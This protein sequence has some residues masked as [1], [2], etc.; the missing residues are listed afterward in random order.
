MCAQ[1]KRL[2]EQEGVLDWEKKSDSER[3]EWVVK[4]HRTRIDAAVKS[5]RTR[6]HSI[7]EMGW[8]TLAVV[9][10]KIM[11]LKPNTFPHHDTH[12]CSRRQRIE[13]ALLTSQWDKSPKFG[14]KSPK[15]RKDDH[16]A[17]TGG[18]GTKYQNRTGTG[19]Y[20]R[21]HF[22]PAVNDLT[23]SFG[24]SLL[25]LKQ[26]AE[27]FTR[28]V[29]QR[30]SAQGADA[31]I[32]FM[33]W[34]VKALWTRHMKDSSATSTKAAQMAD[35][36]TA[37]ESGAESDSED[38]SR[39]HPSSSAYVLAG[40][41]SEWLTEAGAY[42]DNTELQYLDYGTAETRCTVLHVMRCLVDRY[43]PHEAACELLYDN[44]G[45]GDEV[46]V[47]CDLDGLIVWCKGYL[48][49]RGNDPDE[50]VVDFYDPSTNEH[51][52]SI[53]VTITDSE[54]VRIL[55]NGWIDMREFLSRMIEEIVEELELE[56]DVGEEGD[57]D[58]ECHPHI[59]LSMIV[60]KVVVEID[61]DDP[62]LSNDFVDIVQIHLR[63]M[64]DG[65]RLLRTHESDPDLA[66]ETC[67]R[68]PPSADLH[69]DAQEMD[70]DV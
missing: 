66:D 46:E 5:K 39:E 56:H 1:G 52:V 22:Q 45:L 34:R 53:L 23:K 70:V 16:I 44:L 25:T 42:T 64:L 48:D 49:T 10:E 4:A 27:D 30:V 14:D 13:D 9:V 68:L 20:G 15:F 55:D 57:A 19:R 51:E 3:K 33:F 38:S 35:F 41:E 31:E 37:P 50:W 69:V 32:A 40:A 36:C 65:G 6:Q 8:S 28:E 26:V 59:S 61:E 47:K 12:V 11:L 18:G 62:D 54:Q 43:N 21:T 58:N 63:E 67:V 2:A 24:K 60:A 17:L 7:F 29:P